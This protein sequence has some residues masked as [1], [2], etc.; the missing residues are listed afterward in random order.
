M[1]ATTEPAWPDL[2]SSTQAAFQFAA[3]LAIEE[4]PGQATSTPAVSARML[5]IGIADAHPD[6]ASAHR[7]NPL[8]DL[9][10]HFSLGRADLDSEV[11]AWWGAGRPLAM[12]PARHRRRNLTDLPPLKGH[13]PEVLRAAVG[14]MSSAQTRP[15]RLPLRYLFGGMLLVPQSGAYRTLD[16]LLSGRANVPAIAEAYPEFLGQPE[17]RR[18]ADFLADRFPSTAPAAGTVADNLLGRDLLGRGKLIGDMARWLSVRSLQTPLAIGLFGDWGSGKS[19]FMARLSEEI[20]RIARRARARPDSAFCSR[21]VQVSFNAW[22]YSSSDIWP[23]LAFRVFRAIA[24]TSDDASDDA[25]MKELQEY[26]RRQSRAFKKAKQQ[27]DAAD[28]EAR[29]ASADIERLDEQLR[30]F[31]VRLAARVGELGHGAKEA[32]EAGRS[33]RALVLAFRQL[34]ELIRGLPRRW[35]AGLLTGIVIGL[36]GLV[37]TLLKPGVLTTA[38]AVVGLIGSIAAMLVR[39]IIVINEYGRQVKLKDQRTEAEQARKTAQETSEQAQS[40]MDGVPR[41]DEIEAYASGQATLWQARERLSAVTELRQ[42]FEEL[43]KLISRSRG[44]RH[45]GAGSEGTVPAAGANEWA[46]ATASPHGDES[47]PIERI[48]VYID[49]LDRCRPELVVEVL[50]AVKLLM[51]LEHFVV[52]V[53]VD[54]RWLF[55][56]LEIRFRELLAADGVSA[57]AD[58]G[59]AATPQNY[60][61]KI[62]QFSLMLPRIDN[63]GYERLVSELLRSDGSGPEEGDRDRTTIAAVDGAESGGVESTTAVTQLAPAS[64]TPVVGGDDTPTDLLLRDE[65]LD[66]VRGLA[67]L[68]Q[69]PRSA[70]R[71]T[72]I[73]RLIRVTY[74]EKLLL[75]DDSYVVVLVLLGIVVGYPRQSAAVLTALSRAPSLTEWGSF[76]E[77]LAP[78]WTVD[79]AGAR[80]YRS[81]IRSAMSEAEAIEWAALA[82]DLRLIVVGLND[83]VKVTKF[84]PWLPRVAEYTF[85]PWRRSALPQTAA[86]VNGPATTDLPGGTRLAATP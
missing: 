47:L 79:A 81:G 42:R 77:S 4:G 62:F 78:R 27:K 24:G 38:I 71:L 45:R 31:R 12:D 56:S 84:E 37:V 36:V 75:K 57:D 48:V 73:Y 61:E 28:A 14:L 26:W 16:S 20:D 68:I 25:T 52:V 2:S 29:Q 18:F 53:G 33:L 82:D 21:I 69:T 22:L 13:A 39:V 64:G 8:L 63:V 55:R 60:L 34:G 49:D 86:A 19:F 50:E 40:A 46:S 11:S 65:E 72:N 3:G 83:R 70:K 85:H 15:E 51:D 32:V 1:A 41:V 9:L 7:N 76:V 58:G 30:D 6:P 10:L 17:G 66:T 80:S 5:L 23:S 43:S 35:K 44:D 67:R 74:G 59:W 54:S